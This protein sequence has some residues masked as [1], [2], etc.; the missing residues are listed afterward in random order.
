MVK[1]KMTNQ[2]Y[3]FLSSVSAFVFSVAIVIASNRCCIFANHEMID[4]SMTIF[5]K[6]SSFAD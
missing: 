3:I 5:E 1:L 2:N 4:H 6:T